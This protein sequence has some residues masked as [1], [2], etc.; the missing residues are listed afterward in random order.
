MLRKYLKPDLLII[1]MIMDPGMDGLDT[2]KE[3]I[4]IIPDQKAIN[5]QID[6]IVKLKAEKMRLKA[7][8]K[9]EVR[10]VLNDDQRVQ[11]DMKILK[12]AYHGK[13]GHHRGHH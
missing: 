9:V 5:K 11:F 4:A 2:Y 7:A 8:H 12:S 1:D 13:Q 3:I 10:K 6:K